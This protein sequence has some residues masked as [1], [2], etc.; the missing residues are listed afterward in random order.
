MAPQLRE[1]LFSATRQAFAI[2]DDILLID[3]SETA[4]ARLEIVQIL[5][6]RHLTDERLTPQWL[7][8]KIGISA[9]HLCRMIF[10]RWE[11]TAT[12]LIRTRRLYLAKGTIDPSQTGSI[13]HV[14]C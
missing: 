1:L 3:S 13:S 11:S 10:Q 9:A 7:A 5:I 4:N 8:D 6:D 14:D 12:S 2:D